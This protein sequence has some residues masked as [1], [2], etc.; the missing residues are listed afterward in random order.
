MVAARLDTAINER[1]PDSGRPSTR[2]EQELREIVLQAEHATEIVVTE[3]PGW[4]YWMPYPG[5]RY[6][7]HEP[8]ATALARSGRSLTDAPAGR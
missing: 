2:V 3:M 6:Y 4:Y 7:C 8:W 1:H 5:V